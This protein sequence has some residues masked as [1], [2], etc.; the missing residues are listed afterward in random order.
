MLETLVTSKTRIK[1]L[2]KFFLNA[3]TKSYLRSLEGEFGESTNAIRLELNKFE[4]AGMLKADVKGNK[5]VYQAN[6]KHPLFEDIHNIIKKYIGI[7]RVI[8]QIIGK[9]GQLQKV[10]LIGEYAKGVDS[11]IIDFLLVGK[12]FNH[13]YI[14]NMTSIAERKVERKIRFLFMDPEEFVGQV[15]TAEAGLLLWEN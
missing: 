8:E 13:E 10:Y 6:T 9:V 2:L 12:Q 11:G 4:E 1:L 14:A 3:Q 7:D 15:P 5:K